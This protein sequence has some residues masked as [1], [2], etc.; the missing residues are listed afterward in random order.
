MSALINAV[1][2]AGNKG[3]S[4]NFAARN[5]NLLPVAGRP[6]L[7]HVLNALQQVERIG[8]MVV[9]GPY[10]ELCELVARG[11]T[12]YNWRKP[13]ELVEQQNTLFENGWSGFC[14][15]IG[16]EV[17]P[18][19]MPKDPT[20]IE[21]R[22]M[23]MAG[24]LPLVTHEEINEFLDGC[25]GTDADYC[26]GVTE[27]T[28][29]ARFSRYQGK[30]GLSMAYLHLNSG[31]YRLNNMHLVRPFKVGNLP[32]LQ[33]G[34]QARY[35]RQPLNILKAI[36]DIW[37]THRLGMKPVFLYLVLQ[38][39]VLFQA[40]KLRRLLDWTRRKITRQ[41][42]TDMAC[43]IL[44]THA[45]AVET[46]KAGAAIDVDNKRDYETI[47]LRYDEFMGQAAKPD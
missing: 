19:D 5:K 22:V 29:M 1:V 38:F 17:P 27:A 31:S 25:S 30:P 39:C 37:V 33:R 45:V 16:E 10:A 44:Q 34:Y 7:A 23:F 8:R 20:L 6:I 14:H 12:E 32:Y 13:V 46:T 36:Y 47:C 26:C 35:Q 41:R 42:I 18:G 15:A 21:T 43:T 9:V 28:N 2:V 24:D 4:R 40:L 11:R 3:A